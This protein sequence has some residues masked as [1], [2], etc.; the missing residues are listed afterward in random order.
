MRIPKIYKNTDDNKISDKITT[1]DVKS[2][3]LDPVIYIPDVD[4]NDD[5]SVNRYVKC[6]KSSV[7][8]SREYKRLMSFLKNKLDMNSCLFFPKVKKYRDT[9]ISIEIHH[10][11]FVMEDIIRTIL[12]YRYTNNLHHDVQSVAEQIM[13]EHYKGNISLTAF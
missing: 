9:K 5:K 8:G 1:I 12:Q 4:F 11:G 2:E 6:I 3:Q 13:L 10:T 7:R